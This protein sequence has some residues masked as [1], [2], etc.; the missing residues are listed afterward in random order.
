MSFINGRTKMVM[1]QRLMN[2]IEKYWGG[3]VLWLEDKDHPEVVKLNIAKA[4]LFARRHAWSN[5]EFIKVPYSYTFVKVKDQWL[6]VD[7]LFNRFRE[8]EVEFG[9][10]EGYYIKESNSQ[11]QTLVISHAA[12][13][14]T[15][16]T[17]QNGRIIDVLDLWQGN[18]FKATGF[19]IPDTSNAL[20][21]FKFGKEMLDE[22][23][24]P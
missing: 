12:G 18:Q 10:G 22:S 14:Y 23:F 17:F 19:S 20:R 6:V 2:G 16:I 13:Y 1:I 21:F 8:V 24:A 3:D 11:P 7:P 15:E 5:V 4:K 9:Y